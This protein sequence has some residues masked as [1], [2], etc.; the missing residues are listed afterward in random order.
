MV[1]ITSVITLSLLTLI[2][3]CA[4]S[5]NVSLAQMSVAKPLSTFALVPSNGNS[6]EMD[7]ALKSAFL[8]QGLAAKRGLPSGTRKSPEVD[9]IVDY[10]DQWRWDIAMYLRWVN[11]NM[12]EATSG[13]LLASGR[14]ENSALHGFQD[15]RGVLN[16]LVEEMVDKLRAKPK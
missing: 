10:T 1:R 7:V 13:T 9:V 15:Y 14:W 11:I 8:A 12:Y 6:V 4:T 16:G 3:G 5:Q 2:T